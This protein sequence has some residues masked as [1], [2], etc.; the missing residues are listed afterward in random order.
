[1]KITK[2]WLQ[3]RRA[4]EGGTKWFLNQ[5]A[6]KLDTVVMKL[7]KEDHY[8]WV[9]WVLVRFMSHTQK[10][11]YAA[12]AANQVLS[13]YEKAYPGDLRPRA[14]IEAAV[15]F[16]E[17]PTDESRDAANAAATAAANAASYAATAAANA[18]AYAATAAMK[19]KIVAYG[20]KLIGGK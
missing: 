9:Y 17:R 19:N 14:A 1:M 16:A 10:V 13:I 2:R 18:A 6:S 11:T 12:F 20:L 5:R 7:I 4:C 15:R 8:D 3:E